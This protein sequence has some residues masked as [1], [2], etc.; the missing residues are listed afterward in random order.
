MELSP[1]DR[2]RIYNEEKARREAGGKPVA[3][4]IEHAKK[5]NVGCLLLIGLVVAFAIYNA[6]RPGSEAD[7]Y[8]QKAIQIGDTATVVKSDGYFPCGST[9]E[10]LDELTKWAVKGDQDEV[11]RKLITTGSTPLLPGTRVKVLEDGF[12]SR[13]VRILTGVPVGVEC[14]VVTEALTAP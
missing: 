1:E 9:P 7:R 14:W 6:V 8:S 13:K 5:R 2:E 3:K 12:G 4:P 10:A 11:R